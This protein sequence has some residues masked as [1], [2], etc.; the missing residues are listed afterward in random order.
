MNLLFWGLTVSVIGKI[1][2]ASGVLI[3]HSELAHEKRV[4]SLVIKSFKLERVLT[5]TGILLIVGGYAM[6]IYF[7]GFDTNLLMCHGDQCE[8]AAAAAILGL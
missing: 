1:L 2:L 3:A 7:Y 6:E 5:I 4:D 8:T